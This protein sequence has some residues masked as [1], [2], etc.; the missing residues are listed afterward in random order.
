[1]ANASLPGGVVLEGE[2]RCGGVVAAG[3]LIQPDGERPGHLDAFDVAGAGFLEEAV[4]RHA[5]AGDFAFAVDV[6]DVQAEEFA[7]PH[8]A[9]P[10]APKQRDAET[11]EAGVDR[12]ASVLRRCL[13]ECV[14][15]GRG[16][17]ATSRFGSTFGDAQGL[18]DGGRNLA[19]GVE[20]AEAGAGVDGQ[21][22]DPGAAHAQFALQV[23]A[24]GEPAV[25]D[26]ASSP[27]G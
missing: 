18:V 26:F 4:A 2:E 3:V 25:D 12:A 11:G 17:D 6:A 13:E 23:P 16:D 15:L 27:S 7:A 24:L 5:E 10:K 9:V 1:M 19:V 8:A 21:S 22:A 14:E 20:A